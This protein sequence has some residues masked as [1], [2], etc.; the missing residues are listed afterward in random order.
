MV[1]VDRVMMEDLNIGFV[2]MMEYA[3]RA[4]ARLVLEIGDE[5]ADATLGQ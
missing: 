3:G 1:E 2:Q 4:L 5:T